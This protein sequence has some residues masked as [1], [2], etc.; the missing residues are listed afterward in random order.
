MNGWITFPPIFEKRGNFI[1]IIEKG[2]C[3]ELNVYVPLQFT[4]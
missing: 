2:T 4:C 3:D 1:N